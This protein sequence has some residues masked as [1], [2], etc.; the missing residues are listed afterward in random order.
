MAGVPRVAQAASALA[1]SAAAMSAFMVF[2]M[3]QG[4][5]VLDSCL[6]KPL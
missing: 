4:K 3:S 5:Y 1:A 2:S 6:V